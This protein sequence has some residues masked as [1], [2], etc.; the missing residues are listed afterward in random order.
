MTKPTLAENLLRTY[1]FVG[2][3]DA[4]VDQCKI[5]PLAKASLWFTPLDVPRRSRYIGSFR[6]LYSLFGTAW[7]TFS[8]GIG[9]LLGLIALTS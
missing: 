2:D 6:D 8:A 5:E 1:Q 9:A 3:A 7:L 4:P